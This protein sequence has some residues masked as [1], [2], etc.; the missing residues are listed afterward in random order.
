[1]KLTL[2]SGDVFEISTW[3]FSDNG[4]FITTDTEISSLATVNSIV[5][6]QF[7]GTNFTPPVMAAKVLR[8]TDSGIA[9]QLKDTLKP[10]DAPER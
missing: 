4:V 1:M 7:Q 2:A 10:G 5:R 3:D 6:I 9:L 8:V